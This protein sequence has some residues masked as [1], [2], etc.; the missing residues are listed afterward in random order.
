MTAQEIWNI[1]CD[2]LRSDALE[3]TDCTADMGPLLMGWLK[4]PD[5]L[6]RREKLTSAPARFFD[7]GTRVLVI[8][9]CPDDAYRF[10]FVR[11]DSRYRLAFME[12]ITL[13]VDDI[14]ELPYSAYKPLPDKEHHIRC[15]KEI[16]RTVYFYN[17]FKAL[18]GREEAVKIFFDGNGEAV[19]ARSWVPF[20][21]DRLAFIAYEAWMESRINGETVIL[22]EFSEERC[23]LRFRSHSWLRMY[24][25]THLSTQITYEEY[26]G[27]FEAIWRDRAEK[28]GW[29]VSFTYDGEDT[30]LA[31]GRADTP[32]NTD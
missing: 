31:F 8:L 18:L 28:S 1:F 24:R 27:L 15:E 29:T 14:T 3:D 30:V 23:V 17:K 20:Y 7:T 21:S 5:T 25:V 19:G 26:M 22:D 12:C 6:Q 16:L 9:D 32:V 10:H 2:K 4:G 11:E 13:P